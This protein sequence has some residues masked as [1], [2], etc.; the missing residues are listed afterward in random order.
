MQ[1]PERRA[2]TSRISL[3]IGLGTAL[4]FRI[5][6]EKTLELSNGYLA[7]RDCEGPR[8]SFTM[9]DFSITLVSA[10]LVPRR[11]HHELDRP[12][13]HSQGVALLRDEPIALM[14]QP[15][16]YLSIDRLQGVSLLPVESAFRPPLAP[17]SEQP[18]DRRVYSGI[19]ILTI[20]LKKADND[21]RTSGEWQ[22]IGTE[23]AKTEDQCPPRRCIGLHLEAL[24]Y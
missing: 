8:D 4:N 5:G 12:A 19:R 18:V 17:V 23:T 9:Q 13:D 2:L 24:D 11:T 6:V 16:D 7:G 1:T 20:K 22:L 15:A 21:R 3:T 10:G 14:G